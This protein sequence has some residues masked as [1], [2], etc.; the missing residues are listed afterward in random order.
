MKAVKLAKLGVITLLVVGSAISCKQTSRTND[1]LVSIEE[2]N[3]A[4]SINLKA[5]T[6]KIQE[7]ES[8][9]AVIQTNAHVE[10]VFLFK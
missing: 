1:G 7:N 3:H 4:S 5:I 9:F 2:L 8:A 6:V 10:G